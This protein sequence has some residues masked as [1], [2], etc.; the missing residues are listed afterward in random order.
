MATVK[1]NNRELPA[2]A[3]LVG[4]EISPLPEISVNSLELPR[5]IG[6]SFLY[7]Q[8]G[9]KKETLQFILVPTKVQTV[10]SATVE[11]ST[12][13][14]GNNFKPSKI[15]FTDKAGQYSMAQVNGNVTVSD[16]FLYGSLS[17]EFLYTDP[18][19]YSNTKLDV[20]VN[21]P[22]TIIYSGIVP[23]PPVIQYT[24]TTVAAKISFHSSRTTKVITL[25][26]NFPVGTLIT[27]DNSRKLIQINGVT[28]M[29]VLSLDSE[30][31]NL[32]SGNNII[33]IRQNNTVHNGIAV[34]VRSNI[35][36]Y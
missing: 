20:T 30:F 22:A 2:F 1:F 19:T 17:V 3:K 14:R 13:L 9:S 29:K 35:A 11:F 25:N 16:L 34:T 18:L 4:R 33:N 23:Q 24:T 28:N 10:D 12:W 15:E 31:F 36:T 26:G 21:S 5:Q 27:V 32:E 7:T 6:S 8:L